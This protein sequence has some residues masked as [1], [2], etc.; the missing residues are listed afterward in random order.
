MK[1]WN[2]IFVVLLLTI[3]SQGEISYSS[4]V[5]CGSINRLDELCLIKITFQIKTDS[6]LKFS[7]Q[8]PARGMDSIS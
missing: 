1:H 6:L 2:C 8:A 5:L 3:T 7:T 4:V